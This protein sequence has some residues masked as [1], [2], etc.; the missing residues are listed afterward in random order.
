MRDS[1]RFLDLARKCF[2]DAAECKDQAQMKVYAEMGRSYLE[3][4]EV[5]ARAEKVTNRDS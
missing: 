2:E 5:A 4:A 1:E 3:R